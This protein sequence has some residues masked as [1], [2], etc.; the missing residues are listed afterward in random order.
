MIHCKIFV[1]VSC[2]YLRM[3]RSVGINQ[4]ISHI[5]S[6]TNIDVSSIFSMI[7]YIFNGMEFMY[8]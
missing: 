1:F 6:F 5:V 7:S 3:N 4:D 2:V 8:M